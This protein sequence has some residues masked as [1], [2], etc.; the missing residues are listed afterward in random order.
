[1]IKPPWR[2]CRLLCGCRSAHGLDESY[3]FGSLHC[4]MLRLGG[5]DAWP[6][7]LLDRLCRM[8]GEMW[9]DP[10]EVRFDQ[11]EG[12][13]LRGRKG[14]AAP[15]LFHGVLRRH[16]AVCGVPLPEYN[17]WLHLSLAYRGP[18]PI[19]IRKIDPI[20][21]KVE[22]FL[23]VRSNKGHEELGRW[24]LVKRQYALAL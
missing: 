8:L 5:F 17:F 24:P 14:I 4:T 19:G 7:R 20:G 3:P 23:L 15:T 22:E 6:P 12:R 9:F 18:G 13:L 1:M 21:W 2:A 16:A 11:L 10:F